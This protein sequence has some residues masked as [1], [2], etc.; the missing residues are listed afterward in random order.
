MKVLAAMSGGVDSAVAALLVH[1]A[2]GDQLTCVFVDTGLL[3]LDEAEQVDEMFRRQFA[4]D[5]LHV[6]AADQFLGAHVRRVTGRSN[7]RVWAGECHVHA[8]IS[9]QALREMAA[10]R[11]EADLYVHPECGCGTSALWQTG[12][13]DLPASRTH[14]LSTGGMLQAARATRASSASITAFASSWRPRA[15]SQRGLSGTRNRITQIATAPT[16]PN[17]T[18]QRQPSKPNGDRGTRRHA[19]HAIIGTAR[20]VTS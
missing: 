5:F 20:Y 12:T 11:P 14:V 16:E 2:I 15:A 10:A 1:K 19:R 4:V 7:L 18:T 6:K 8:G 3:R 17:S 13:G 9:P